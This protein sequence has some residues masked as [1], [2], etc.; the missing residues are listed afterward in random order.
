LRIENRIS[1]KR[2]IADVFAFISDF[3]NL[4]KWNRHILSVDVESS[5]SVGVGSRHHQVRRND[6]HLFEITTYDPSR[7]LAIR[8]DPTTLPDL[9]IGYLLEA[10]G[11]RTILIESLEL[12]MVG[13]VHRVAQGVARRQIRLSARRNLGE[14]RRLLE[15]AH[16]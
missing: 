6:E 15:A 16:V 2:S 9:T 12:R 13:F 11:D 10:R 7:Q 4:P 8:R 14:L 3:Q 1:I 5:S